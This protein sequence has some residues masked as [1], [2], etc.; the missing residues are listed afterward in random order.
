MSEA[1]PYSKE[2][3]LEVTPKP[4]R[5]RV[6]SRKGWEQLYDAKG[7]PCR[8]CTKHTSLIVLH[9]VVFREDGGDDLPENLVP[10]CHDDHAAIHNR[11][12]AIARLLLARLSD[13]E[14]AYMVERGG[15]DYAERVYGVEYER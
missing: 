9:H 3:Q 10:L 6:S 1:K 8:V 12:P 2:Q 15:E 14:Y 13:A 4:Y 11:A 7:G 5:R